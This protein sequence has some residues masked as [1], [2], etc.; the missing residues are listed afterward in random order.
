M[1]T[2]FVFLGKSGVGKDT[3]FNLI[4]KDLQYLTKIVPITTR[5]IRPGEENGKDYRFVT[6]EQFQKMIRDNELLEHRKYTVKNVDDT[7]TYWYYGHPSGKNERYSALIGTP[8][9]CNSLHKNPDIY[10]IPIYINVADDERL[11]RMI[12][13]ETQSSE[14]NY[15]ELIRRYNQDN[16]DFSSDIMYHNLLIGEDHL[17]VINIDTDYAYNKIKNFINSVIERM[18][19]RARYK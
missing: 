16:I 18:E 8:E 4:I 3:L 11:Y 10:V 19:L 1:N 15:R 2:V 5:P 13:R 12:K 14:P 6:D 9:V 17:E 7:D